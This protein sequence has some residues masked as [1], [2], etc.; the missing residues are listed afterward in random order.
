MNLLYLRF[1]NAGLEIEMTFF[2]SLTR[3]TTLA[4]TEKALHTD[5]KHFFF[6][7]LFFLFRG[8]EGEVV[9]TP[10]QRNI[11]NAVTGLDSDC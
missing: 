11:T 5:F 6:F 1:Q 8:W 3:Y 4:A 9:T 7:F 2:Y 10:L